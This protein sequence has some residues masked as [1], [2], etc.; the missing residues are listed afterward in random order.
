MTEDLKARLERMKRRL[1]CMVGLVEWA[2]EAAARGDTPTA[3]MFLGALM[4]ILRAI[5]QDDA[6]RMESTEP[7]PTHG[8]RVRRAPDDELLQERRRC[9]DL[10]Q[11]ERTLLAKLADVE[12]MLRKERGYSKRT[13]DMYER[14]GRAHEET[15]TT[16]RGELTQIREA[17]GAGPH[18]P[19]L[20]AV[21]R[22]VEDRNLVYK[23]EGELQAALDQRFCSPA[24][25]PSL[26]HMTEILHGILRPHVPEV[27]APAFEK[28]SIQ[29]LACSAV[30]RIRELVELSNNQRQRE[31]RVRV[32][33]GAGRGE[34]TEE[35]AR[36]LY[37]AFE[38]EQERRVR[39]SQNVN[40]MLAQRDQARMIVQKARE[41]LLAGET[42]SVG[43]AATRIVK[44]LDVERRARDSL[45]R[46]IDAARATERRAVSVL[47]VW[48]A[49]TVAEAA[50]A[51]C[52]ELGG[53]PSLGCYQLAR[54]LRQNVRDLSEDREALGRMRDALGAT[55]EESA[56]QAAHRVMASLAL[57]GERERA[58]SIAL[59]QAKGAAPTQKA[60]VA[61]YRD[62][63]DAERKRLAEAL[64][65]MTI[66][67]QVVAPIS[68]WWTADRAGKMP[69]PL[70]MQ[71]VGR[72][73][74]GAL[75]AT[76]GVL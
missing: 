58:L 24:T 6:P 7:G 71:L 41:V 45:A 66:L 11:V 8:S 46:E 40:D 55:P 64:R 50:L 21:L 44:A 39:L 36:R 14:E 60:E 32:V 63:L 29:A 27:T 9:Q 69:A 31:E 75:A 20:A 10:E 53:D 70:D 59:E 25:H 38:V 61:F 68:E 57:V 19:T 49:G 5:F 33:I 65:R 51:V 47:G 2:L 1:D 62:A 28:A 13:Y 18:E 72:A 73:V 48:S 22:V 43:E 3:S 54:R 23:R 76:G 4:S 52:E 16:L 34:D 12:E 37:T 30:D 15:R 26:A 74:S 17:L 42:E 56:L 67:R 35:A